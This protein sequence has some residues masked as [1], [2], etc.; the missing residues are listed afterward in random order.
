M[1][2]DHTLNKK[3]QIFGRYA[4][5]YSDYENPAPWTSNPVAGNGSGFP[6]TYIL[7]DQS[8]ALGWTDTVKTNLVNTAHFG[9][10]RT[11]SHSD[12]IGL[13]DGVS[14]RFDRSGSR[15]FR[16]IP[17][18]QES[19]LSRRA[20]SIASGPLIIVPSIRWPRPISCSTR[21]IG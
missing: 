9:Y 15:A 4:F 18:S 17:Q 3:N 1:R 21:C 12:P 2:V 19:H 14:A 7:H 11:Y 6:T 10:L 5:D 16:T 20:G 8:V 13:T